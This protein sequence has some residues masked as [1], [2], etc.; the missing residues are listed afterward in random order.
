MSRV[1]DRSGIVE[2]A[3]QRYDR[4]AIPGAR[5]RVLVGSDDLARFP[6]YFQR[7]TFELGLDLGAD[8]AVED[9]AAWLPRLALVQLNFASF[10]DGRA[11]SQARQLRQRYAYDGDIRACGEVLRDQLAFMERCGINQFE[12][13]AGEDLELALLAFDDISENY[14]PDATEL[15]LPGIV[16]G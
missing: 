13:A 14:Q 2:A 6:R 1:I 11:F 5:H 10:A 8:E 15:R 9:F 12:L 4:R 3:W 7:T 16:N